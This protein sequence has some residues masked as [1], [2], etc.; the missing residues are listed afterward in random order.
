MLNQTEIKDKPLCENF[1]IR[2]NLINKAFMK[3]V[4]LNK[5]TNKSKEIINSALKAK[6]TL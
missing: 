3:D 6:K 4:E 2:K 1:E 5:F